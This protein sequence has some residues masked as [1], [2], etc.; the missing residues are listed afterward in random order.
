MNKEKK[1]RI[2]DEKSLPLE[3]NVRK[4]MNDEIQIEQKTELG[5]IMSNLDSD[6]VDDQTKMSSIDFNTRLSP[7]ELKSCLIID[8]LER[9]EIF[10]KGMGLTRQLKRLATSKNGM[11]RAE[12]VSI[13]QGQREQSSM[14]SGGF[15]SRMFRKKDDIK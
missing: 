8:T 11:S 1:E 15:L 14:Q 13:V 10:P 12:K 7:I 2:L 6:I 4:F 3:D 5:E 9:M